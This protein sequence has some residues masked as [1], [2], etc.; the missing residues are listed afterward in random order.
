[1]RLQPGGDGG[2]ALCV[3]RGGGEGEASGRPTECI[4]GD[5]QRG[6]GPSGAAPDEGAGKVKRESGVKVDFSHSAAGVYCVYEC[7]IMWCKC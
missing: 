7:V 6:G 2:K 4:Q 5:S 1:M 3:S